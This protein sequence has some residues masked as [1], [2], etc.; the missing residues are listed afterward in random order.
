MDSFDVESIHCQTLVFARVAV[1]CYGMI[2]EASPR[3]TG[4]TQISPRK[5][6]RCR[7]ARISAAPPPP[8]RREPRGE[9]KTTR[10]R[11][12][13][14]F[15]ERRA[16]HTERWEGV[17]RS[18][19]SVPCRQSTPDAL[20]PHYPQRPRWL[21]QGRDHSCHT[22]STC[23]PSHTRLFPQVLLGC[24]LYRILLFPARS[25]PTNPSKW[26]IRTSFITYFRIRLRLPLRAPKLFLNDELQTQ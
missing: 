17:C 14:T 21:G 7:E 26:G 22:R 10:T 16:H 20:H 4:V 5:L 23:L 6:G 13:T 3:V 18:A 11:N 25:T 15:Q 24:R 12:T 1:L 9:S 19:A 8:S 2:T